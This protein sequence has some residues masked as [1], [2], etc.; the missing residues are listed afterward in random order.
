MLMIKILHNFIDQNCRNYGSM[1][2][3][4]S[5]QTYLISSGEWPV[6]NGKPGWQSLCEGGASW[7]QLSPLFLVSLTCFL[8]RGG[9]VD[10]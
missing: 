8:I 5:C 10:S 4:G 9:V 7:G 1:V 3:I 2:E 6:A